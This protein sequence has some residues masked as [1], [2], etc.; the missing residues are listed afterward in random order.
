MSLPGADGGVR[1]LLGQSR[2]TYRRTSEESPRK[3]KPDPRRDLEDEIESKGCLI[4]DLRIVSRLRR[5]LL[6][7]DACDVLH[8][9]RRA[10][11]EQVQRSIGPSGEFFGKILGQ[12]CKAEHGCRADGGHD[13]PL[14]I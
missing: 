1:R 10:D 11:V 2:G 13:S 6:D 8:G 7:H 5:P 3:R 4:R 14:N 12:N 9:E